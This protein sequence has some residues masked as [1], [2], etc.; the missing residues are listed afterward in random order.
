MKLLNNKLILSL[1]LLSL[2]ASSCSD[3]L[4]VNDDPDNLLTAPINNQLTSLTVNLGYWAGSDIN[5][6]SLLLTQQYA[7]QSTGAENQTQIF[8][9]YRITGTDFN[10]LYGTLYAVILNDAE[11]IIK[12]ATAEG[13]PHYSGV[14]KIIK[15]Y[16]YHL[17][18]DAWGDMPY[19]EAQGLVTNLHPAYDTDN[20]IYAAIITLLD[21]GI[22]EVNATTSLQSPGTNSTIFS[23]AFATTKQNWVRL[24]NTLKLRLFLHYS[25]LDQTFAKTQIDA[26]INSG[27]EFLTSNTDNFQMSF[28]NAANSRNPID[29]F[30][31][32]RAGYLV[33]NNFLVSMMNTKADPRRAFYFTQFPANSGQYLGS[34]PGAAASQ[35]Y[36]K[37]HTY[38]RGALAGTTYTGSAPI[39]MLTFSEYNF[40]RSEAALRMSSP[41]NAQT[42][43]AA[44][45][46]ASMENAGV[47]EA[48]IVTYLA[49]HGTLVGTP[50]QQLQQIIEEKYIANYGVSMEPWTDWRRTGYPLSLVA[51]AG[52]VLTFIP[53][54]LY[55]PQ[56][57]MDFN[58]NAPDQ[59]ASLSERIF[60]DTRP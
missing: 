41:G 7:G 38:L 10:N 59:K 39:R 49:A 6:Y 18:V 2:L 5:R 53:R 36:S 50:A 12:A 52:A 47:V 27:A 16:A 45:I 43:F 31:T 21:Q 58:V 37:V 48:A 55:Y 30:E 46:R 25:E 4:E 3:F 40:I 51:P 15:A 19:S 29:Q 56:S 20:D 32:G 34:V 44:G 13:S 33:A 54:S 1:T 14:A 28:V 8:E 35:N 24:A 23:G 17:A 57:D 60:W 11:N 42:F 22:A 9:T 26:L